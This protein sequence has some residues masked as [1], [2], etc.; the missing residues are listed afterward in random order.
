MSKIITIDSSILLAVINEHAD[1]P[2]CINSGKNV[3]YSGPRTKYF[4]KQCE[5]NGTRILLPAPV[6]SE[7][8]VRADDAS[9]TFM[10]LLGYSSAFYSVPFDQRAALEHAEITKSKITK[11]GNKRGRLAGDWQK[12][13]F[14]RQIVAI[15]RVFKAEAIYCADKGLAAHAQFAGIA[16]KSFSDME[17]PPDIRAPQLDLVVNKD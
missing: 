14:D 8:L 10:T 2:P 11:Y 15:S 12:I 13:K 4:L 5:A 16:V 6:L 3:P 7:L 1:I 17:L 9:E